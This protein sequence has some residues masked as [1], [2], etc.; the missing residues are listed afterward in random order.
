MENKQIA[1][2]FNELAVLMEYHGES[3]FKVRSYST[4][5]LLYRKM[6]KPLSHLTKKDLLDITGIGEA[7]ANKTLE[8][9]QTGTFRLLEEYRVK[10][11]AGIQELLQ[12]R[13]LGPK[14]V[15]QLVDE[16]GIGNPVDLLYACRENRL[17]SLSGFGQKSQKDIEQKV[18]YYLDHKGLYLLPLLQSKADELLDKIKQEYPRDRHC[19]TGAIRRKELVLDQ[20]EILSTA[21]EEDLRSLLVGEIENYPVKFYKTCEDRFG[22]DLYLTTRYTTEGIS[23]VNLPKFKDEKELYSHF[24]WPYVV[25][26]RRHIMWEGREEQAAELPMLQRTDIRGILHAHSTFSDG[27]AE[28]GE[29]ARY[30]KNNGF[31]YLGITDHSKSAAYAGGMTVEKVYEQWSTIDRLNK[32]LFPFKIFKGIESDILSDGSLDYP[33]EILRGFDF[34]IASIHSGMQMDEKKATDRLI[35]A[36]ENP[37]TAILGHPTGRLLLG[38][39]GYPINHRKVIDAAASNHVAIEI[40]SNPY[41]LDLDFTWIPYAME[42]GVL[43]A[44]N[45]DAHQLQGVMDIEWGLIAAN[46]GGLLSSRLLN[47]MNAEDISQ[48]FRKRRN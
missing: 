29:L 12:I 39:K 6:D 14:K 15:R 40:N 36:I 2:L 43:L 20:I 33:E 3:P 17:I 9:L 10:T 19:L 22:T 44:I 31:E 32:E 18:Q 21:P 26:L 45:P 16:L 24:Q 13:G 11:P 37:N 25:P 8:I 4:A 28:L 46:K 34:V 30:I 47:A 41:R 1:R 5:Y 48:F 38:R 35:K 7:I 23:T 42:K 27:S